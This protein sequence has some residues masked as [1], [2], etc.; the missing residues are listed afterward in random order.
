MPYLPLWILLSPPH[1]ANGRRKE[2]E[3]WDD[4]ARGGGRGRGR[5]WIL[6]RRRGKRKRKTNGEGV[7]L[8]LFLRG[9][10]KA[11]LWSGGR[12]NPQSASANDDPSPPSPSVC[13]GSNQA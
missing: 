6:R 13:C 12:K 8:S 2:E 5:G 1:F 11:V 9:G 4:L 10:G 3:K 7:R